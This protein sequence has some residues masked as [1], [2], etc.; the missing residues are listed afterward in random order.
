[1]A[2]HTESELLFLFRGDR[3][4]AFRL[5]FDSYY[6]VLCDYVLLIIDDFEE[7]EDIVQS[8]FVQFWEEHLEDKIKGSLK[9][10]CQACVRNAAFKRKGDN[11]ALL[12]LTDTDDWMF[13]SEE[14]LQDEHKE[15]EERLKAALGKLSVKEYDALKTVIMEEKTYLE[16]SK[17]LDISVNTLK[18]YLKRAVKKLKESDILVFF[19]IFCHPFYIFFTHYGKRNM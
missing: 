8:F 6:L 10:Y 17:E 9:R 16:A 1:M 14:D 2:L 4:K 5:F 3:E 11:D 12:S 19:I 15:I 13:E 7:A 18:T